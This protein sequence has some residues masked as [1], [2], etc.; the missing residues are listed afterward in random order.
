MD[1]IL[2]NTLSIAV[3]VIMASCTSSQRSGD[4][5]IDF[6]G[7][8]GGSEQTAPADNADA[9]DVTSGKDDFAD[10]DND[11][12]QNSAEQAPAESKGDDLSLDDEPAKTEEAP[13][14]Q[15][16][17]P[18]P[19]EQAPAEPAP[20]VEA[21]APEPTPAPVVN[22]PAP[23]PV[24][25]PAPM[26][27][28][29][30]I[31]ITSLK[32]KANDNGGTIVIDAT[33]PISYTTRSNPE[34]KQMIIEVP[35]AT[36]P[37]K[38][39]RP[40]NTR[41][42]HG[43]IGAI[44]PYQNAGSTTARF[45][46]QLREGASE[47]T[48]QQ[49]GNSLLVVASGAGGGMSAS[50]PEGGADLSKPDPNANTDL[51]GP[52]ILSSQSLADFLSGNTK[53]YGK[54]ISIE[55][56][57]MDVRDALRFITEESGVNMV[58]AEEVRGTVSLKL[59]QVPWDQALVMLM[60]AKGLGYSRQGNVLRIATVEQ[61]K[62]EED[63]ATR[64]VQS[65]RATEPL[66][67]R[68]FPISYAQVADLEKRVASF[69]SERG[70]VVG[71][72]RTNALVVTDI[73]EYLQRVE[74]LVRNLDTQ[75]PQVLIEAKI[76]EATESFTRAI[77]LNWGMTNGSANLGNGKFGPVTMRP[78]FG[79]SA[80]STSSGAFSG[81]LNIGTLD[82]LGDL[83]AQLA[84]NER[85]EKVK[86]IS[87]PRIATLSNE[88]SNISQTTEVPVKQVTP[89]AQGTPQTTFSF[90]PLTLKLEVTPQ[91]TADASIIM[92]V[93]LKREFR[94]A[95]L[96]SD[97]DV[98]AVNSREANTK[99]L[100]KNGQTAV[101]GGIY[102]SDATESETGVPYLREI[103]F[104]GTLFRGRATTKEK[105]ELLLFLTP[106]VAAQV[107][108]GNSGTSDF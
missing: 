26:M 30:P 84:L 91:V 48:V 99:I 21:P 44:D 105:S 24:E 81:G 87:S 65:K 67:V 108:G 54:R 2:R 66:K 77:G 68:M 14:A 19:A 22:E 11:A 35:N 16:E 43:T 70:K 78:N 100:I 13:P 79:I 102:Q 92:K 104:L 106:R 25:T 88:T 103:P 36:L 83:T 1:R 15:A 75:P 29:A 89:L 62:K 51:S 80:G 101:I 41:D 97:S 38:L 55:T 45:V 76:V 93:Q 34:L 85:E 5:D 59:R 61:L 63:D 17:N 60:K 20:Q 46:I 96:Q 52:G 3:A 82:L 6:D 12:K 71:D 39:Q 56:S 107:S 9:G 32:Y 72:V 8:G 7:A 47:P 64:L 69:L 53:F 90:K 74:K 50:A 31:T 57:N 37:K 40:L 27:S 95:S 73:E 18:P 58:I 94:G 28:S 42:M 4:D 49:E 23:A 98:F 33:G 10:F 86:V